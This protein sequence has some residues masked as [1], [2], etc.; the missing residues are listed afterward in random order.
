[1]W[2]ASPGWV[3]EGGAGGGCGGAELRLAGE[4]GIGNAGSG[5]GQECHG[6]V[7]P[8]VATGSL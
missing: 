2:Y 1:M 6:T 3:G 4:S 7:S 8:Q 5:G